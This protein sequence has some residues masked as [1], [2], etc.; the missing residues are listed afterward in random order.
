MLPSCSASR[1]A[2]GSSVPGRVTQLFL[3]VARVLG[4]PIP[5]I[6]C[7]SP[8]TD[9]EDMEASVPDLRG[10]AGSRPSFLFPVCSRAPWPLGSCGHPLRTARQLFACQFNSTRSPK[11][12]RGSPA[13]NLAEPWQC[14]LVEALRTGTP[15]PAEPK[16]AVVV[17]IPQSRPQ[18]EVSVE[19]IYEGGAFGRD[20][21]GRGESRTGKGEKPGR[22]PFQASSQPQPGR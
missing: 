2:W 15:Q 13:S 18:G 19:V 20:Q 22:M 12:P 8:A 3:L 4:Q 1:S 9:L 14:F 17:W 10:S 16:A 7:S 21:L 6:G 11:W 5:V